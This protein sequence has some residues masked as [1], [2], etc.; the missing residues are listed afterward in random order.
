MKLEE[1]FE[2]EGTYELVDGVYNVKGSVRLI[3]E[4][5]KL[6]CKF[7]KVSGKFYCA[8]NNLTSLEGCPTHVGGIFYCHCNEL[9]SLEGCPT[10]V[11]DFACDEELHYTKEYKQYL[12]LKELRK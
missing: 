12:I 1:Y 4:V 9:K 2:I 11:G 5:E 6:P 10:K 3:K 8:N 7:G